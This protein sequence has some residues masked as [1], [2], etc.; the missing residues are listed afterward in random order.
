M[1]VA[2]TVPVAE[3]ATAAL[4]VKK[5]RVGAGAA[6]AKAKKDVPPKAPR[7]KKVT[8]TAAKN[9]SKPTSPP[10]PHAAGSGDSVKAEG[11]SLDKITSGIKKITLVTNQQKQVRTRENKKPAGV[12][13]AGSSAGSRTPSLPATPR[14]E[15]QQD[16][17]VPSKGNNL[18]VAG[19]PLVEHQTPESEQGHRAAVSAAGATVAETAAVKVET[20]AQLSHPGTPT[21]IFVEYKPNG[22]SAETITLKG[23]LEWLPIN[24]TETPSPH[25]HP[26]ALA[27]QPSAIPPVQEDD[28]GARPIMSPSPMKRAEVP[29]FTPMS[30]LRFAPRSGEQ[31]QQ[32]Q[33]PSAL[34]TSP[35]AGH[36]KFDKAVWAVPESPDHLA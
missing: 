35:K 33:K 17:V 6:A 16:L 7:A 15:H 34:P 13:K 3:A 10:R 20:P 26:A 30:Q 18:T 14:E 29:V 24:T 8:T 32:Q 23:P 9:G 1:S 5:S 22:P 27:E 25:K 11:D 12:K 28:G 4:A 2:T 19:I 21:D 36:R 31:Q